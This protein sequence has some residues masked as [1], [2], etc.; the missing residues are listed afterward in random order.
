MSFIKNKTV[1]KISLPFIGLIIFLMTGC[2]VSC[3]NGTDNK[4]GADANNPSGSDK[5]EE[6]TEKYNS[7]NTLLVLPEKPAP[8]QSFRILATGGENIKK[9]SIVVIGPSGNLKSVKT[10]H[11]MISLSGDR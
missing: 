8:G 7:V 1:Y 10:N 11:Q 3:G 9:A 4:Q 6:S 5:E 2:L